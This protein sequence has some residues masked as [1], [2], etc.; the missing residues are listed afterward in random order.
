VWEGMPKR[1]GKVRTCA[2]ATGAR[3]KAEAGSGSEQ[4][5]RGLTAGFLDHGPLVTVDEGIGSDLLVG[6]WCAGGKWSTSQLPLRSRGPILAGLRHDE[7]HIL[8]V[9]GAEAM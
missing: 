1:Q 8:L 7:G 9:L 2:D 6:S 4:R 5:E 3:Q